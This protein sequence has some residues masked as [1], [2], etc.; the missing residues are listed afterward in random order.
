MAAGFEGF[1]I[2]DRKDVFVGAAKPRREVELF[3][4]KGIEFRATKPA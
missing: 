3:G 2:V 1:E 4:T